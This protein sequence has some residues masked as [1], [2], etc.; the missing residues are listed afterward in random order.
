MKNFL[1]SGQGNTPPTEYGSTPTERVRTL[2]SARPA[3]RAAKSTIVVI[4]LMCIFLLVHSLQQGQIVYFSMTPI[5]G[6]AILL[7]GGFNQCSVASFNPFCHEHQTAD[8]SLLRANGLHRSGTRGMNQPRMLHTATTLNDGKVLVVG[9]VE[10]D[11]DGYSPQVLAS[12]EIYAP[13]DGRWRTVASMGT[14][15]DAHTATLLGDGRVLVCCGA[16]RANVGSAE[17][18]DPLRAQWEATE[19]M[20]VVRRGHTAT[21]LSSGL[22]AVI[23]G[24]TAR[25]YDDSSVD[26]YDPS[27]NL[28]RP[29]HSMSEGRSGHTATLLDDGRVLVVGGRNASGTLAA[30]E[31]YDPISDTWQTL[32]PMQ[33]A[34]AG[35]AATLLDDGRVLVT[36]GRGVAGSVTLASV[37]LFDPATAQWRQLPPMQQAR[38]G[39]T[40]ILSPTG[41][42][43]VGGGETATA[44]PTLETYTP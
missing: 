34:R 2:Q 18:Y 8:A 37:E 32:P 26:I 42:V 3:S 19:P 7:T 9:G 22:V 30:T 11:H 36:G 29:T 15:R 12:A 17:V 33:Q 38:A 35:H 14:A 20:S 23:G 41:L 16:S 43:V 44:N 4:A 13:E 21:R 39:H 31:I 25:A 1:F 24:T 28:W 27:T 10:T 40:A 6:N 5:P